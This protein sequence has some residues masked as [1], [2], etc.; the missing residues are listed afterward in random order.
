[1][2]ISMIMKCLTYKNVGFALLTV[3]GLGQGL[4]AEKTLPEKD[5]KQMLEELNE[6][7]KTYV[8]H[9]ARRM[10]FSIRRRV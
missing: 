10:W 6:A 4:A 1:M 5:K 8:R 7:L 2:K 9:A 3:F